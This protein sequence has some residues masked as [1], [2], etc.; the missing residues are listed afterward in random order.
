MTFCPGDPNSE[1]VI[2]PSRLFGPLEVS[3]DAWITFPDGLPG[4]AGE[5]RFVVL[6]AAGDSAFWLQSVD[7]GSLVFLLVDPFPLVEGYEVDLP[8]VEDAAD[9]VALAIVT[10]PKAGGGPA[11][12]NLQG[13]IIID[14]AARAGYQ[15]IHTDQ[16]FGTQFP[17]DLQAVLAGA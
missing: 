11:S 8:D 4:F 13:P 12:M 1:M 14:F 5:Q 17:V 2:V 15:H 9:V 3:P 6:P 7:D 16:R 10:L